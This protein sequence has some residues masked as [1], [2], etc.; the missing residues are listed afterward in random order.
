MNPDPRATAG[1][2][3]MT[4]RH[5]TTGHIIKYDGSYFVYGADQILIGEYSTRHAA[6]HALPT[7]EH[8]ELTT[9]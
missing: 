7:K 9:T 1:A 3:V 8:S 2:L 4:V 6:M 5:A